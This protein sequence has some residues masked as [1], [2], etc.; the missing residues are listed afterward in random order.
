MAGVAATTATTVLGRALRSRSSGPADSAPGAPGRFEW[1]HASLFFTHRGAGA[2][3]LLLHDLSRGA[4]GVEMATLGAR[5]SDRFTVYTL[6]LPGHG[7]SDDPAMKHDT[8]FFAD[9]VVEF[10]RHE[11]GAPALVVASGQT[12][13]S[14]CR[15]AATTRDAIDR[16]VLISPPDTVPPD[17]RRLA[18]A[19]LIL[20]SSRTS[21]NPLAPEHYREALPDAVQQVVSGTSD[22]RPHIEAPGSVAGAIHGWWARSGR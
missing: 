17:L 22:R 14:A 1:R 8:E 11:I 15:A 19:P 21:G 16:L 7:R 12:A 9:A 5:L 2:P 10:V 4:S 20:W 18:T 6:D 13:R 3:L